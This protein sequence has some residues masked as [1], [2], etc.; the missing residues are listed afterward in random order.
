MDVAVGEVFAGIA[1]RLASEMLC[2]HRA[3]PI[4]QLEDL[5]VDALV[6]AAAP[7]RACKVDDHG[8]TRYSVFGN[9]NANIPSCWY[10]LKPIL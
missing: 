6:A 4:E 10:H 5:E 3:V 2:E 8:P 1:Q 9:T 7:D